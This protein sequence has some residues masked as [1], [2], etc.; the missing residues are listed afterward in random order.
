[1]IS[2][3]ACSKKWNFCPDEDESR[4]LFNSSWWKKREKVIFGWNFMIF[5]WKF[6]AKTPYTC[7]KSEKS[8][9]WSK[10]WFSVFISIGKKPSRST[11]QKSSQ[12][13]RLFTSGS[14]KKFEMKTL[15]LFHTCTTFS[16]PNFVHF[17]ICR[18]EWK[19][20]S[21]LKQNGSV[22]WQNPQKVKMT[23]IIHLAFVFPLQMKTTF[24][25]HHAVNLAQTNGF[26]NILL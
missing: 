23:K 19:L 22:S 25:R 20:F 17:H 11:S 12:S 6:E 8:W 1:M 7:Q 18:P 2:R 15:Q 9:F 4:R 26:T 13:R 5:W 3:S 14:W 21:F 10:K 24:L 16:H